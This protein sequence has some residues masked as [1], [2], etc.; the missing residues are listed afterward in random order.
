[1][2]KIKY[3]YT[4]LSVL[5]MMISL[6]SCNNNAWIEHYSPE[7]T[8]KSDLN[9]YEYI[10]A[11][12]DLT[13]FA[14]MLEITGY[15]S[16]L[17]KP[18]AYTVWAPV[19]SALSAIDL[20]DTTTVTEI[21]KNHIT[22]FSH[23]TSGINSKTIYML[24]KKFLTF[25]K[26]DDGFTFGGKSLIADKSNMATS[27][28]ILHC[29]DGF[30]P[31][32]SNIWEYIG[33]APGLDSLRAYLYSQTTYEFDVD[34]SVEIGTNEFGQAIY[35][36]V[37]TFKNPVLDKIGQLQIEDSTFTAI[38]PN[39]AAWT[40]AY[41]QIKNGY[42][43]L[44]KD[45]GVQQQ[46]LNT[47]WALVKNLV[48]RKQVSNP[49]AFDSLYSSTGSKFMQPA[50]LFDNAT[51]TELSNGLAYVTDSLRFKAAESWQQSIKIEAENSDYGRSYVYANL[52]GRS[53]LGSI[54][55]NVISGNKYLIVEPTTVS[56]ST[57]NAV[58]FPIP[59][60]LSGKY[61]IYCV[62]VP[63]NAISATDTKPYKVS[64]YFSY[65]DKNGAQVTDAA[66]DNKNLVTLPNRVG[67][68]FTTN[69]TEITKMFVTQ[70]DFP[71]CNL[72]KDK[73]EAANITIKLKVKSEA[74][75]TETA[76]VSRIFRV[77]YIILEP[78]Q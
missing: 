48:F 73:S 43:T 8:G 18:Q 27:N 77:D 49:A 26:T 24:G 13:I 45:G 17:S 15:D 19:N 33:K 59:N 65:L 36:S 31:Y 56:N 29:I 60:T 2:K 72:I 1:M 42:K 7:N 38:L 28:G 74:K 4:I 32:T 16:I 40:K 68:V 41:N 20:T 64:Y 46:R 52:L 58:T 10:N 39:N 35:D 57:Q 5:I 47:Q 9:L 76:L 25:K 62:F 55:S 12:S 14:Q 34:A 71:F 53:G 23:P 61:N 44:V 37:I 11:Q 6:S 50:Y 66:I 75:I 70:F 63:G 3:R 78:V 67:N 22:R 21:I 30:V 69:G 51:K 54:Y